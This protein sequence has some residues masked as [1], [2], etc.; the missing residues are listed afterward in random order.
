[1][2]IVV[3]SESNLRYTYSQASVE[4]GTLRLLDSTYSWTLFLR[5][6]KHNQKLES[7]VKL[8]CN[9]SSNQQ[10]MTVPLYV[11]RT[12]TFF[13]QKSSLN[14]RFYGFNLLASFDGF[15]STIFARNW[16]HSICTCALLSWIMKGTSVSII[17]VAENTKIKLPHDVHGF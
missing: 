4:S 12:A 6:I 3:T 11:L 2:H 9:G 8:R 7:R 5:K 1:M 10:W 16:F 13:C 15:E 14:T 17:F